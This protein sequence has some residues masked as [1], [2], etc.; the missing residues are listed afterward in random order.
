MKYS[1]L[2][3]SP[4]SMNVLNLRTLDPP[5]A[6]E[7]LKGCGGEQTS[8]PRREKLF[9]AKTYPE[10]VGDLLEVR[11]DGGDLVDNVLDGDDAV[12]AKGALDD[13]VGG[14]GDALL[15]DLAVSTLV[16]ELADGLKVGLSESGESLVSPMVVEKCRSGGMDE[17][18]GDVGLDEEE[19]LGG[20]LGDLDEDTVVDLEETEELQDLAGLGGNVVDTEGG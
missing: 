14:K 18:V 8:A 20:G 13:S 16:D 7:S 5:S 9:R 2:P 19:H 10:E 11:A 12:L 1:R 17:P 3:S 6:L 4:P 15:V